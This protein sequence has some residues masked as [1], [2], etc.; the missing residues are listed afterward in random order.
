VKVRIEVPAGISSMTDENGDR[1]RR[2][3]ASIGEQFGIHFRAGLAAIG[4]EKT[5][6]S[7]VYLLGPWE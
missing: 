7:S 2:M 3:Q 1:A 5:P 4:I 6:E